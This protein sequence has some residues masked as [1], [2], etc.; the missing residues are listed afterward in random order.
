MSLPEPYPVRASHSVLDVPERPTPTQADL[1]DP[2][3]EA[4]W[5][6]IKTWDIDGGYRRGY[7][8]ATGSD[9]MLILNA[10]RATRKK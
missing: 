4:I 2:E 9:V 6:V 7:Y 10:V 5:Q 8:G 3:F 1:N